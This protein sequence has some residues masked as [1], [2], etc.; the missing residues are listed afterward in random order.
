MIPMDML[1][2]AE[3]IHKTYTLGRKLIPVLRGAS[4][5]VARGETVSIVG[6]SGSGKSTL[7]HIL[8]GLDEPDAGTVTLCG[9]HFYTAPGAPDTAVGCARFRQS[10]R[11]RSIGFVFQSYQLLPELDVLENAILPAMN[12]I[13]GMAGSA[14]RER[15]MELLKAVGLAD[16][17]AH[18]PMELSGGEQQRLAV[19]RAMMNNPDILL[20]DEPTGN[21]D[22]ATGRHVLDHV[23]NLVRG[24]NRALVMVTHNERIAGMCDRT[25]RLADGT[26][27]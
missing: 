4:L 1:L 26:L 8:G 3:G 5:S 15:G 17:A 7:L 12:G 6:A 16:R 19:A 20:A 10:A 22:D 9:R 2:I 21:L 24:G 27:A 25:L 14:A 23:F 18:R 13:G 11:A